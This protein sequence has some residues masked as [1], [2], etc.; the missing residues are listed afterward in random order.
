MLA[1]F[2]TYPNM[3]SLEKLTHIFIILLMLLS[4]NTL[5]WEEG[6]RLKFGSFLFAALC[7]IIIVLSLTSLLDSLVFNASLNSVLLLIS[8][9]VLSSGITLC[10]FILCNEQQMINVLGLKDEIKNQADLCLGSYL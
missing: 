2:L 7:G 4:I 3:A 1:M 8:G 10:I 6:E 9:L 5:L